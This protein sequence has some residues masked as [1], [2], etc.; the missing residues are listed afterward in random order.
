MARL[1][2]FGTEAHRYPNKVYADSGWAGWGDFLGKSWR[3]FDEAR[4]FVRPL[5]LKSEREWRAFS[6]S[7]KRPADIPSYPARTYADAGWAGWSDW[8][9]NGG[10]RRG[11]RWRPFG[12]A[13]AHVRALS[14]K[15]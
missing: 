11:A 1:V 15:A 4:A 5:G 12:E 13:R 6:Q 2:R 10:R 14:L 3:P 8:L 7:G 9:G